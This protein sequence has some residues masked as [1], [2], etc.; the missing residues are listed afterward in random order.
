MAIVKT[1]RIVLIVISKLVI[2]FNMHAQTCPLNIDFEAG[3]FINWTTGTG[4]FIDYGDGIYT[5][6]VR[7]HN[8]SV[9][10]RHTLYSRFDDIQKL[11]TFGRFPVL[12]PNGS[13]YSIRLGNDNG[14]PGSAGAG[15]G[16]IS[17]VKYR[18]TVP[19][20][21]QQ[22][23]FNYS[24][25]VV[26]ENPQY[27]SVIQEPFFAV[28]VKDVQTNEI[29]ECLSTKYLF[30]FNLSNPVSIPSTVPG[31][32]IIYQDWTEAVLNFSKLKG[33]TIEITFTA[34]DSH[35]GSFGYAYLDID[36]NCDN[37]FSSAPFCKND[38]ATYVMAPGGYAEYAWY[39]NNFTTPA[40]MERRL[41]L[42]PIPPDGTSLIM[43]G[44]YY[45]GRRCKDTLNYTLRDTL[46]AIADAG[47]NT[48][49][50]VGYPVKLGGKAQPGLEYSWSPATGL[51]N[52]SVAN[53]FA[54][55]QHITTYTV[56]A[57]SAGGGCMAVDTV[58]V[59]PSQIANKILTMEGKKELCF[60]TS[61][62]AK[63]TVKPAHHILW[64]RDALTFKSGTDTSITVFDR[65][66]YYAMLTN[67]DG[68]KVR[69]N[70][71]II[72]LVKPP[73][74]ITYPVKYFSAN[75]NLPLGARNIGA[76]AVWSPYI[77]LNNP[78]T[79]KPVF[80]GNSDVK[81][82]VELTD[83]FGCKTIDIQQVKVFNREEVYVPTAFTPNKDGLNDYLK[84]IGVNIKEH[85]YFK[86]YNRWGQLVF[87]SSLP[88]KGWNGYFKG[89]LQ[90]TGNFI[91]TFKGVH[92][93]GE[94]VTSSGS[95]LLIH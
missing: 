69:T 4:N 34:A 93:N 74:G 92:Y 78:L 73:A 55:P 43:V 42:A 86:I 23:L 36:S 22:Y 41:T 3:N 90:P 56:T 85:H 6:L 60:G 65:G 16:D 44:T 75:K 45:T 53:P 91:W 82:F 2:A 15:G 52:D 51:S 12:C 21:S 71:F 32:K 18:F 29:V 80:N 5:P 26:Y 20:I 72:E 67:A 59:R 58:T 46:K 35:T 76:T 8:V 68:C 14:G 31:Q 83:R 24:F 27:A 39:I 87:E 49:Y 54:S 84:P 70:P 40:G 1:I 95:F 38:T 63:F 79:Y 61:D 30:G 57:K 28:T 11:D 33:R 81:Y 89:V 37:P 9:W 47:S 17:E 64:I 13:G 50:C 48:I 94:I 62:Y 10:D 25:A 7:Y 77:F 19:S 66:N 88:E